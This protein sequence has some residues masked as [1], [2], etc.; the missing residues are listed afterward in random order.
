M[1]GHHSFL[2]GTRLAHEWTKRALR[3]SFITWAQVFNLCGFGKLKT[4]HHKYEI[5]SETGPGLSA[6]MTWIQTEFLLKGIYLGL[7]LGVAMRA[8]SWHEL[9]L[10]GLCTVGGLAVCLTVAAF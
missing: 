3:G 2:A 6:S 7:L 10:V 8:P 5:A 1:F 9:A 4:C